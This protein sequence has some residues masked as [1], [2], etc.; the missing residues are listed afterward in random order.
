MD[1]KEKS[2]VTP[3]IDS[4]PLRDTNNDTVDVIKHEKLTQ[5]YKGPMVRGCYHGLG[6]I[7]WVQENEK[8]IYEGYFYVNQIHGYG[9]M[10]YGNGLIFEGLFKDNMRFGPGVMTYPDKF[11]EVGFWVGTSIFRLSYNLTTRLVPSYSSNVSIKIKLLQF[12]H[13]IDLTQPPHSITNIRDNNEKYLNNNYSC[14]YTRHFSSLYFDSKIFDTEFIYKSIILENDKQIKKENR[15]IRGYDLVDL[16]QKN[17]LKIPEKGISQSNNK[18]LLNCSI[19]IDKQSEILNENSWSIISNK[20]DDFESNEKNPQNDQN[21]DRNFPKMLA[22][23]NNTLDKMIL[24]HA[25]QQQFGEK[26]LLYNIDDVW[27]GKRNMFMPSHSHELEAVK[28]LSKLD[29]SPENIQYTIQ[30]HNIDLDVADSQGNTRLM[31]SS[32]NDQHEIIKCLIKLGADLECYNDVGFTP[33]NLTIMRY[34]CLL[35]NINY[36]TEY[37]IPHVDLKFNIIKEDQHITLKNIQ[38]INFFQPENLKN[39]KFTEIDDNVEET[40]STPIQVSTKKR[41]SLGSVEDTILLL[42]NMGAK[43][44]TC[45][46]PKMTIHLALLTINSNIMKSVFNAGGSPTYT[47]SDQN[48]KFNLLH[49]AVVMPTSYSVVQCI[50]VLIAHCVNPNLKALPMFS[51]FRH[52]L[53]W[54]KISNEKNA[55]MTPLDIFCLKENIYELDEELIV[56]E[57]S[58]NELASILYDITEKSHTYCGFKPIALAMLTGK[59]HLTKKFLEKNRSVVNENISGFGTLLSLLL[60]PFYNFNLSNTEL[61][62]LLDLLLKANSNPLK[63]VEIFVKKFRGNICEYY[64]SLSELK[65]L[66]GEKHPSCNSNITEI[67]NK[68]RNSGRQILDEMYSKRATV[69]LINDY[70]NPL[71]SADEKRAMLRWLTLGNI[72]LTHRAKFENMM[73]NTQLFTFRTNLKEKTKNETYAL[74]LQYMKL[75]TRNQIILT[76]EESQ[77]CYECLQHQSKTMEACSNCYFALLC[78]ECCKNRHNK[79]YNC[80]IQMS[81]GHIVKFQNELKNKKINKNLN[82][83]STHR[84]SIEKSIMNS[85][86]WEIREYI[87]SSLVTSK[88]SKTLT[89]TMHSQFSVFSKT[90][91][92]SSSDKASTYSKPSKQPQN[93]IINITHSTK[94]EYKDDSIYS[95]SNEM[96]NSVSSQISNK[97]VRKRINGLDNDKKNYAHSDIGDT[98]KDTRNYS[99]NAKRYTQSKR[100]NKM[101]SSVSSQNINIRVRSQNNGLDYDKK[102]YIQS[103]KAKLQNKNEQNDWKSLRKNSKIRDKNHILNN[104]VNVLSIS[105]MKYR[106]IRSPGCWI[107]IFMFINRGSYED[108][109]IL[110]NVISRGTPY[111]LMIEKNGRVYY[112]INDYQYAILNNYSL[113]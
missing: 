111:I 38:K 102:N 37:L 67:E 96:Y 89:S 3:I 65:N 35:N 113:I 92:Y 57:Q 42:I 27:N 73:P 76:K 108:V 31:I 55:S 97:R 104:R 47:L 51:I 48:Y 80:K 20:I 74:C 7:T 8:Q 75:T 46:V 101:Y 60:N 83:S 86:Q 59:L 95:R 53:P 87:S 18:F 81:Q 110:K 10:I 12:R 56:D 70:K 91:D 30:K 50:K 54:S 49:M 94:S 6:L 100:T 105:T 5:I 112:K 1:N 13:L 109:T 82:L 84:I 103:D 99:K 52:K 16:I 23:N 15:F 63:I 62:K 93:K 19:G 4:L 44:T 79:E 90:S 72:M 77:V 29:I 25:Y 61:N 68:L 66:S 34:I 22:Y 71:L 24:A 39:L 85:E 98:I 43:V 64:T 32:A 21:E 2:I 26:T 36:W 107:P 69:A 14:P 58:E 40:T 88:L 45:I 11:Q 9:R 106:L 78:S 28:L 33:L 41:T 17:Y